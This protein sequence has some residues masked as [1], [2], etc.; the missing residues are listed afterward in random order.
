MNNIKF[1]C[2]YYLHTNGSV[3]YKPPIVVCEEFFDSPF[4]KKVWCVKNRDDFNMMINELYSLTTQ[5]NITIL[6]K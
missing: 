4:V 5:D 6:F 3:I 2:Y 1:L